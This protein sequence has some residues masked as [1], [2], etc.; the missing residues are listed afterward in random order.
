MNV[1]YNSDSFAV[2]QVDLPAE[3]GRADAL[4]GVEIVD[5]S[6]RR[7]IFLE[8]ELARLFTEQVQALAEEDE[9]DAADIDA[10]LARYTGEGWQPQVLH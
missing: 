4:H 1:L 2:L 8:G 9:V 5:K 10:H 3:P 7:G 6:A